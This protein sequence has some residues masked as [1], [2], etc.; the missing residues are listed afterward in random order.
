MHLKSSPPFKGG[1]SLHSVEEGEQRWLRLRA[2]R[3]LDVT[4][5]QKGLMQGR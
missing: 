4:L 5:A 1:D 3:L 2:T